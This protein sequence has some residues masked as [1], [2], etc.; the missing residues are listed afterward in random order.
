MKWKQK[1]KANSKNFVKKIG[2][3]LVKITKEKRKDPN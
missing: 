2:K 3:L 1:K